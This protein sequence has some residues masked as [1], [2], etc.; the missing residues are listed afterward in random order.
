MTR[1]GAMVTSARR[2][3]TVAN[4][5]RRTGRKKMAEYIEREK[6]LALQ[7]DLHFDN[8]EQ[9]KHWKCR[10]IDPTEVQLLPA[11]DVRPVVRGKWEQTK[12]EF[13]FYNKCSACGKEYYCG[14]IAPFNFCPNCGA[15]MRG[16][17]GNG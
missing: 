2:I 11:A 3:A 7:T 5:E 4:T 17:D 12:D 15:D 14:P 1:A 9:L 8:I 13:G 6:V 16:G 10:H